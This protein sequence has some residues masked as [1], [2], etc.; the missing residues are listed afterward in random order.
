MR[1]T[2]L[3]LIV[4]CCGA[5]GV[6]GSCSGDAV[7]SCATDADCGPAQRCDPALG[8][9]PTS[10]GDADA[11]ADA[12]ADTDA[13]ADADADADP[14]PCADFLARCQDGD[15][16]ACQLYETE[17]DGT[18]SECATLEEQCAMGDGQACELLLGNGCPYPQDCDV[19]RALCERGDP[20]ACARVESGNCGTNFCARD[21]VCSPDCPQGDPDCEAVPGCPE[22]CGDL[23]QSA[24]DVCQWTCTADSGCVMTP[25]EQGAIEDCFTVEGGIAWD[26]DCD[27]LTDCQDPDCAGADVCAR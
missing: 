23:P 18:T 21:G 16:D 24:R 25:F 13:D 9:V 6:V 5:P 15:Q 3:G 7:G 27:G 20:E 2:V 19:L 8:C 10:D 26:E 14:G 4:L 1:V 17:C 12:D 22:Q 11:D